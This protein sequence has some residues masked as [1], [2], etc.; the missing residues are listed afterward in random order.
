VQQHLCTLRNNTD[1]DITECKD[2][3]G[4]D[5]DDVCVDVV[6]CDGGFEEVHVKKL[7]NFFS[8]MQL[9]IVENST[10]I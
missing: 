1:L 8:H 2:D 5:D 7:N 9:R 10:T 4:D 3:E 6:C